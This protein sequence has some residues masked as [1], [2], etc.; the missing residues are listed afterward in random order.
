MMQEP[1]LQFEIS[2]DGA[3]VITATDRP[4]TTAAQLVDRLEEARRARPSI[5]GEL[6]PASNITYRHRTMGEPIIQ[7][8]SVVGIDIKPGRWRN[9]LPTERYLKT[10]TEKWSSTENTD[11]DHQ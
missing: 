1:N 7:Q 5:C 8:G 11:N 6:T 10:L 3:P 2:V 4:S 9:G